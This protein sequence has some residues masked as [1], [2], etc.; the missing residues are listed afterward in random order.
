MCNVDMWTILYWRER[1]NALNSLLNL[2]SIQETLSGSLFLETL[3]HCKFPLSLASASSQTPLPLLLLPLQGDPTP[4]CNPLT[5][6]WFLY[7]AKENYSEQFTGNIP[8]LSWACPSTDLIFVFRDFSVWRP[9]FWSRELDV[10]N[11]S[12]GWSWCSSDEAPFPYNH[13][14]AK[15]HLTPTFPVSSLELWNYLPPLTSKALTQF[16]SLYLNIFSSV[17]TWWLLI[18]TQLCENIQCQF[19]AFEQKS[20]CCFVTHH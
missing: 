17:V 15:F 20:F 9:P 12:H 14:L 19:L 2:S 11:K 13:N 18:F 10:A 5:T 6:S 16:L 4:A 1:A 7:K 3:T 8:C